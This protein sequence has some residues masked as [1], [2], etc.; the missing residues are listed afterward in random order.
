MKTQVKRY[1]SRPLNSF[2][3]NRVVSWLLNQRV[4]Y[5]RD[6]LFTLVGRDM[7]LRYKRSVLGIGWS[8]LTPL[9]QLSVYY[10]TFDVLLPLNIPNYLSFLFSGVLVW[11]WFHGAIYQATSVSI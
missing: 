6:L 7:K 11:N 4:I 10:L 1:E 3:M 5:M 8:L 2:S 9:A